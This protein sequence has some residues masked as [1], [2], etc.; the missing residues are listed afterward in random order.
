MENLVLYKNNIYVD[1]NTD[2]FIIPDR[3]DLINLS[4]NLSD[5]YLFNLFEKYKEDILILKY[6]KGAVFEKH[7]HLKIN[8]NHIGDLILFPPIEIYSNFIGGDLIL[9]FDNTI[10]RYEPSKMENWTGIFLP[11]GIEHSVE[12]VISGIRYSFKIDLYKK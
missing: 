6:C 12:E 9:Y 10:L 8:E 4:G 2:N 11:L 1:L 5:D 3:F 7:S